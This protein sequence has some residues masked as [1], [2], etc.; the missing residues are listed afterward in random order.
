[1]ENTV[2]YTPL[3]TPVFGIKSVQAMM[4]YYKNIKW[5]KEAKF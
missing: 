2:K 3:K 1:M 4:R 5:L